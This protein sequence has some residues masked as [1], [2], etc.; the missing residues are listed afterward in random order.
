MIGTPLVMIRVCFVMGSVALMELLV[1]Q[2]RP[3]M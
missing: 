2:I 1:F 3:C